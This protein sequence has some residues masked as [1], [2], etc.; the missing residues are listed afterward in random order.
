MSGVGTPGPTA[1]RIRAAANRQW[2]RLIAQPGRWPRLLILAACSAIVAMY[3]L[4]SDMGGDPD[5]PRGDGKYRPVLARGDGH[6]LY[7]MA[8]STALD[9]DWVFDNDLAR[10]GDPWN[11]PRTKTGRKAIIHPIGP[12]LVWTPLIWIAE[13]GAVIVNLFG[14]DVP[15][16]GYS[17]WTQRFVFLSSALFGCGAALLGRRLAKKTIGGAWS[18]SYAATCVLLGTPIAYYATYM[19]S[20][21]HAMDAFACAAFLAYWSDTVGRTDLRRW[22]TLGVL[23]G[24]ATLVRSQELAMGIVVAIEVGARVASGLRWREE[25]M[26]AVGKRWVLGGLLVLGIACVLFLPQLYEWHVVFGKA[27][28]LPQ[29]AKYTR[30][31]A[32][33]VMELLFAPRNGWFPTTPIAYFAVIGL[34]C[35]PKQF[36][37][38]GIGMLAAVA[39]QV[40]LNSTILD[41]W[42]GAA[43]GQ[44]RLCNV[45]L[46]LVFGL[47]TLIWRL[48]RL[49]ARWPRVPRAVWHALLVVVFGTL[50]AANLSHVRR[51]A[52]GKGADDSLQSC[53]DDVPALVRPTVRWWYERIGN[54]FEFPANAIFALRHHVPITRWN[55]VVGDYPIV[56]SL[57]DLRDDET[58][59]ARLART[60]GTWRI[61]GGGLQR[62]LAGGWSPPLHADRAFRFTTEARATVLVPNLMPYG[63]RLTLWLAAGGAH[64][65]TIE[66]NGETVAETDLAE[67]WTHVT[68]DLP[69]IALHTNELT[70][71]SAPSDYRPAPGW[72]AVTT[73]VG[74]AVADLELR[75]LE[76]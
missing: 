4:N 18:A 27:T 75:F 53:C 1:H 23:L 70:V 50:L 5:S 25:P 58:V 3:C 76:L 47:A 39:I 71:V 45:T 51:L 46:P 37:L 44:R 33:M 64:H 42:G 63:Q 13:A 54:P 65:A 55:A 34:V 2:Q 69:H 28:A 7:L 40:Y 14:A 16:H 59:N 52:G 20:Y 68:F 36:R 38:V 57:G 24:I 48:G 43:F 60:Q 22:I 12:A 67:T 74:V 8:R 15:L 21:S 9:G 19:P 31:E 56:P 62:F 32:P 6:M 29:G 61:G 49:V 72:P 35:V 10:F 66:W 41:W 26:G 73:A 11:E 17:L 30:F